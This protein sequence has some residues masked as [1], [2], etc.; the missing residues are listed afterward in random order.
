MSACYVCKDAGSVLQVDEVWFDFGVPNMRFG[1]TLDWKDKPS[2][3]PPCQ[4]KNA[5]MIASVVLKKHRA[6]GA[7]GPLWPTRWWV[8]YSND[9]VYGGFV[10]DLDPKP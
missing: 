3:C 5:H 6:D 4:T 10:P 7:L 8:R 2:L 9:V 1:S